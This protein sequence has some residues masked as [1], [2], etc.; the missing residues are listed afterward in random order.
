MKNVI[1]D[2]RQRS[3]AAILEC[4][5]FARIRHKSHFVNQ[6]LILFFK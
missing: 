4:N 6:I 3:G 5:R 1:Y 2:V